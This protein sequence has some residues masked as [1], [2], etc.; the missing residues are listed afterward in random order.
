MR[1]NPSPRENKKYRESKIYMFEIKKDIMDKIGYHFL[2][3]SIKRYD[4]HF[5]PNLG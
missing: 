3:F 5:Y 1:V 4:I 2:K